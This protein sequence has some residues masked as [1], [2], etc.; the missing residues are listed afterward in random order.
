M[1]Q[2]IVR[3]IPPT[4]RPP[5]RRLYSEVNYGMSRLHGYVEYHVGKRIGRRD[6]L[7]P[8]NWLH[9]VSG[10]SFDVE[11]FNAVGEEFFRYFVTIGGLQPDHRVLDVGSG[12]GRMAR[13]LTRYLKNGSYE[14]IDIVAPSVKWC[15]RTFTPRYP[16]FRFQFS[17]IYNKTYNPAG[18]CNASEYSFPFETSSFDFIFLTSV[19]THM[20]PE[21]LENYFSEVARVLKPDGRSLITYILLN[22]E[23]LELI[24]AKISPCLFEYRLPGCRVGN[25][26]VPEDHVAYDETTIRGLYQKHNLNLLE[27]IYFGTWCGRKNGLSAQDMIVAT[28][29]R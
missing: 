24:D 1:K 20:L 25:A 11:D 15:Q 29:S 18:E 22:Q 5:L 8:P 27:P 17:D 16:N 23:S 6:P 13:P 28:K 2:S 4:L 14:G 21:D 9:S 10:Q 7:L 12:T 26:D 19:F 3:L